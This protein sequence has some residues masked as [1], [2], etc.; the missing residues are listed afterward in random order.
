MVSRYR[1]EPGPND[2]SRPNPVVQGL[3]DDLQLDRAHQLHMNLGQP[4][5]PDHMQQRVFV[6]QLTQCVMT[7]CKVRSS[8]WGRAGELLSAA[9]WPAV[10]FSSLRPVS[11]LGGIM[12]G[13]VLIHVVMAGV[14]AFGRSRGAGRIG[15]RSGG[16]HRVGQ[17]G[18]QRR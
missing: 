10:S 13:I 15:F 7:L 6:F 3:L 5:H 18:L 12:L 14:T 8:N 1:M 16:Q 17:H 2:T 4:L 11:R 9:V